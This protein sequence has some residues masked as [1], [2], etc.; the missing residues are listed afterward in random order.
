[1]TNHVPIFHDLPVVA[2]FSPL[3]TRELKLPSGVPCFITYSATTGLYIA[4]IYA[5]DHKFERLHQ[6]NLFIRELW[7]GPNASPE[8]PVWWNR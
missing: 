1:M 5:E 4:T 2:D 7:E 3:C 8:D 6:V